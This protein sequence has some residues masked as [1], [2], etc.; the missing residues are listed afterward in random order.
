MKV[1]AIHNY[2]VK[3]P[4]K[5]SLAPSSKL[6]F[7]SQLSKESDKLDVNNKPSGSCV[8]FSA[9]LIKHCKDYY[10]YQ[11]AKSE[12]D[13]FCRL[14]SSQKQPFV[15]RTFCM[16]PFEGIQ[17]GIKAFEGLSMKDI[18]Y[19]SE[20]LHVIAVKRG[21]KNGCGYCYADA[22]P[23]KTE[24]SWEDFTLITRGYKTLRERFHGVDLFGE[25][26]PTGNDPTFKTTELFYDADCMN[27]AIKD[28]NGN[29][30]DFAKLSDEL[31]D[32]LGRKTVFDTSGW[33]QNNTFLQERAEKYVNH[34]SKSEN[35]KK[36]AQFAYSFNLFN[37]SYIASVKALKRG[38]AEKAERLRN[39]FTDNAANVLFTFS[40]LFKDEKFVILS[41]CLKAEG[42]DAKYFNPDAMLEVGVE[43]LNKLAL[44]YQADLKGA[45]KYGKTPED[46]NELLSLAASKLLVFDAGINS[47]GR[48]KQFLKE[49]DIKANLQDHNQ[50][51]TPLKAD[52]EHYGRYHKYL[53]HKLIDADGKV[54]HMNYAWFVP[55]EIQ[56]NLSGKACSTPQ[57]A[58]IL[59]DYVLKKDVINRPEIQVIKHIKKEN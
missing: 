33:Y 27:L 34:F 53:A 13:K 7:R 54:Y 50:M 59:P 55:T 41:R 40:P 11:K 4:S 19:M 32:G 26:L 37:A 9:N 2:S 44:L 48:M 23:S 56:L 51:I 38:D 58:N 16:E 30:Y 10:K 29:L 43:V 47:A 52:L 18:Q 39:R 36:L 28:K 1:S 8:N 42:E 5:V 35:M 46:L 49:F 24:M 25:K 6:I 3:V 31:Y 14:V 22:K 45:Q 21:C 12:V 20:N 57:L 17:Y 15:L